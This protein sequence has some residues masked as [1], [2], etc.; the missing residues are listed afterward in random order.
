MKKPSFL[1]RDNA[2]GLFNDTKQR[3]GLLQNKKR[4]NSFIPALHRL[5]G[6]NPSKGRVARIGNSD[7]TYHSLKKTLVSF[8]PTSW[9]EELVR[10]KAEWPGCQNWWAGFPFIALMEILPD[11]DGISGTL[12]LHAE[13]GP[14]ADHGKRRAVILAIQKAAITNDSLRIRFPIGATDKGRLYSRFLTGNDA[15]VSDIH[16]AA[17]VEESMKSLVAEFE[18]E[19]ALVA[20]VL[21]RWT[22]SELSDCGP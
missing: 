1:K 16:D 9:E 19:F 11:G 6:E 18:P 14:V 21:S 7:F 22:P 10:T 3:L 20:D 13:V 12:R 15:P 5:F 4:E 8:L 2:L 17:N